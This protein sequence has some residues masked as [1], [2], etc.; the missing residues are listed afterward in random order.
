MDSTKNES[1]FRISIQ[2]LD[3][4]LPLS[5]FTA[6]IIISAAIFLTL[7]NTG[8]TFLTRDVKGASVVA[9]ET[10]QNDDGTITTSVNGDPYIGDKNQA[11]IA[12]IEYTDYECPYCKQ[13]HSDT[14]PQIKT[15]W[16][17]TGRI[18]YVV[19][20]LPLSIHEPNATNKALAAE[21]INS[22]A[23]HEV[24]F[25]IR[26]DLYDAQSGSVRELRSL[27]E[28]K[29]VDTANFTSCLNQKEFQAEVEADVTAATEA[30]IFGT[31]GFIVGTLEDDGTITGTKVSGAQSYSVFV[32]TIESYL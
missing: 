30:G 12:I 14:F 6:S 23:G 19:R 18:V 22:I 31:P 20:D 29:G 16:V 7:Q 8:E 11:S 32:G 28:N 25:D 3:F 4:L 15:N 9:I 1:Q 24:Y 21:C 10:F 17:D 13:F 27:I 5:I 2:T 26:S